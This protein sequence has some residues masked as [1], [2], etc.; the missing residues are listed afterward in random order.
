MSRPS[1]LPV[2]LLQRSLG[3]SLVGLDCED[4]AGIHIAEGKDTVIGVERDFHGRTRDV[5]RSVSRFF[6][7]N[8]TVIDVLITPLT[9]PLPRLRFACRSTSS[10]LRAATLAEVSHDAI[11]AL[12]PPLVQTGRGCGLLNAVVINEEYAQD[13]SAGAAN[14]LGTRT[15]GTPLLNWKISAIKYS[16]G[17]R[18]SMRS[19][20]APTTTTTTT[21]QAPGVAVMKA[22]SRRQR[23]EVWR[24]LQRRNVKEWLAAA[25]YI[26]SDR[27][28]SDCVSTSGFIRQQLGGNH[29]LDLQDAVIDALSPRSFPPASELVKVHS[30]FLLAYNKVIDDVLSIVKAELTDHPTYRIVITGHSLGGAIASLAPPSLKIALPEAILKLYTFDTLIRSLRQPRVG[31]VK[32]ARFVEDTVGMENIFRTVHTTGKWCPNDGAPRLEIRA[33]EYWQFENP[34][35]FTPAAHT[36]KHCVGGEDSTYLHLCVLPF[37]RSSFFLSKSSNPAHTFY[38]GQFEA[39]NPLN[40]LCRPLRSVSVILPKKNEGGSTP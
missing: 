40:L 33:L 28:R 32:Y 6:L 21:I 2:R 15:L 30:G 23:R 10:S 18:T 37:I 17:G 25:H 8:C 22:S 1:D 16:T 7:L 4:L 11:H 20:T 31:D 5:I 39:I 24:R 9:A 29:C 36:V 38:F 3:P 27:Y 14:Q 26:P 35:P 13:F 12:N 34:M 19:R